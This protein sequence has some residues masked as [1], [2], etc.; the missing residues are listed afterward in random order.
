M[1]AAARIPGVRPENAETRAGR[2]ACWLDGSPLP[3]LPL[4][5]LLLLA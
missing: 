5:L 4:L 2:G 3:L 1:A